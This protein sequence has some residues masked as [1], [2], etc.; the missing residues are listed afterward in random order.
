MSIIS[1][2]EVPPTL[3]MEV[4]LAQ[5][6]PRRTVWVHMPIRIGRE[7]IIVDQL[8]QFDYPGHQS[9]VLVVEV[10]EDGVTAASR[11]RER[12]LRKAGVPVVRVT[13]ED[14]FREDALEHLSAKIYEGV[15]Q[16]GRVKRKWAA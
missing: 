8:V 4:D 11:H 5:G 10:D 2:P 1:I 3:V 14:I 13:P 15:Q 12:L 16:G 9:S 7:E 6:L